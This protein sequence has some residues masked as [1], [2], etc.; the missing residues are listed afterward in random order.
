MAEL[1]VYMIIQNNFYPNWTSEL[2]TSDT[3]AVNLMKNFYHGRDLEDFFNTSSHDSINA[4]LIEEL[5]ISAV[6][7]PPIPVSGD[8]TIWPESAIGIA[9][10]IVSVVLLL[11]L[12]CCLICCICV[13]CVR[14]DKE[15]E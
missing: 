4:M 5:C 9:V 14:E 7:P 12:I 13:C 15:K 2:Y 10:I 1:R 11:S 6:I 8:P 3:T